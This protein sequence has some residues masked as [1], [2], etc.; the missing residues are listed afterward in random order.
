MRGGGAAECGRWPRLELPVSG[1]SRRCGGG[2]GDRFSMA[3]IARSPVMS[4]GRTQQLSDDPIKLGDH[5]LDIDKVQVDVVAKVL[6]MLVW[7]DA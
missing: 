2:A 1:S 6:A 7:R 5:E 3:W 4:G